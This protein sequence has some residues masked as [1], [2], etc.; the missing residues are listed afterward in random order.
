MKVI[1][2][3]DHLNEMYGCAPQDFLLW[4]W[5]KLNW[6]ELNWNKWK[7]KRICVVKSVKILFT[8]WVNIEWILFCVFWIHTHTLTLANI[9]D[10]FFSTNFQNNIL[11]KYHLNSDEQHAWSLFSHNFFN[12]LKTFSSSFG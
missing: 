2:K 3:M 11:I 10:L 4:S 6:A 9:L 12:R 8:V 7:V 5:N 1:F